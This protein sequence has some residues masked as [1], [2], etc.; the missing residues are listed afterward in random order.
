VAGGGESVS[1]GAVDAQED[2]TFY[3]VWELMYVERIRWE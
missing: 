2:W 1:R 3:E